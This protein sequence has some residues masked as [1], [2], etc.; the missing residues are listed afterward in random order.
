MTKK[1]RCPHTGKLETKAEQKARRIID[2]QTIVLSIREFEELLKN[3]PLLLIASEDIQMGDVVVKMWQRYCRRAKS[4][5]DYLVGVALR[6]FKK[7]EKAVIVIPKPFSQSFP[8]SELN[9][10]GGD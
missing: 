2:R 5:N 9:V 3:P 7:G 4:P 8:S 10:T 1:F 6:D